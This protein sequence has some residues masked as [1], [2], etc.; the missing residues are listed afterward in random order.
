VG[1]GGIEPPTIE[2]HHPVGTPFV[3]K[4]DLNLF[5]FVTY[6]SNDPTAVMPAKFGCILRGKSEQKCPFCRAKPRTVRPSAFACISTIVKSSSLLSTTHTLGRENL[7]AG[8]PGS[9]LVLIVCPCYP[10]LQVLR[11][12]LRDRT[13]FR[14][15]PHH[16]MTPAYKTRAHY[17][18]PTWFF[19]QGIVSVW[20][21]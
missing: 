2:L 9:G 19:V 17:N 3:F 16:S 6:H 5:K 20:D 21:P 4:L 13:C 7:Y 8:S 10:W 1:S 12:C 11:R 15:N 18:M 14:T